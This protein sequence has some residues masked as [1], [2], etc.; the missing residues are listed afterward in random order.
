MVYNAVHNSSMV[1]S[2]SYDTQSLQLTVTFNAGNSYRYE[3]VT[4]E[5]YE[6]FINGESTGKA[7]NENIR[8]YNGIKVEEDLLI[9]INNAD[10]QMGSM[11]TSN[12]YD[13]S[14]QING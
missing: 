8:K 7:F 13:Q 10:M 3:G 6:A 4:T 2:S 5:D 9:E 12:G 1:K 11:I 14:N